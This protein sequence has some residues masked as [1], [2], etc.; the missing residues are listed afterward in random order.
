MTIET[1]GRHRVCCGDV[2]NR[3]GLDELMAGFN[4][5]I[6]YSDPPWGTGNIG[7]WATMNKKMTGQSVSPATMPE[8]LAA[9]FECARRTTRYVIIEYG[10]R[11]R[12]DIIGAGF[13]VGLQHVGIIEGRYG[14]GKE[15]RPLDIHVFTQ[16]D[17]VPKEIWEATGTKGYEC[18]RRIVT[19]LAG[20]VGGDAIIL[21][22]CCGMGY[23]AQA[24]VDTGL[25]FFGNELNRIRLDKTI[26]RL[27]G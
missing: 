4:P 17:P 24:A 6:L 10:C 8:L 19:P 21:D 7:Y 16:G 11:W 26:A 23:T 15:E 12:S 9:V 18:V 13:S 3:A 22:P 14:S 1:Y 5:A 2:T 27:K 20:L 25:R